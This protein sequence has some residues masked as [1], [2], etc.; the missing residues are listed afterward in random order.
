LTV[1]NPRV[2]SWNH[3]LHTGSSIDS[4]KTAGNLDRRA[5]IIGGDWGQGWWRTRRRER[6]EEVDAMESMRPVYFLLEIACCV[7]LGAIVCT[8]YTGNAS[9][10]LG[11]GSGLIVV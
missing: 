6:S 4:V 2:I 7:L 11:V 10:D 9:K 3:D 5:G 1:A 8:E